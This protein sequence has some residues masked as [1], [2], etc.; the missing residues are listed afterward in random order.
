MLTSKLSSK[1]QITVPRKAREA[2]KVQP[3]DVVAYELEEGAVRLRR[4]EPFDAAFHA[5]LSNTLEE[6]ASP[7][8]EE[9][10]RDL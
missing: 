7:E 8:D 4:L 5:A 10:F 3:G 9:A 1:S 6:W 2:L